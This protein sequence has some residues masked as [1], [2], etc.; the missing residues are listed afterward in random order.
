MT[1]EGYSE[2]TYEV[3]DGYHTH[4]DENGREKRLEP[5]AQ[6]HPTTRQ[7]EGGT[8]EGKARKVAED[9]STQFSGEDIGVRSLPMTDAALE[10]ALDEELTE[11]DFEGVEPEGADEE[12]LKGQVEDI[13]ADKE[14]G[15]ADG[16][17]D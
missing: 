7:V 12:Y 6:F 10:L 13:V 11:G 9:T 17:E 5:G 3:V 2:D 16:E 1:K 14:A 15:G 8:L 4:V